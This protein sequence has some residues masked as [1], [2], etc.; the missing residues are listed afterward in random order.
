MLFRFS[1]VKTVTF[2]EYLFLRYKHAYLSLFCGPPAG[3]VPILSYHD[4]RPMQSP[5]VTPPDHTSCLKITPS[6]CYQRFV[7]VDFSPVDTRPEG[8]TNP[9]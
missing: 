7:A 5:S 3:V 8:R 9:I 6:N 2:P 1:T 4:I